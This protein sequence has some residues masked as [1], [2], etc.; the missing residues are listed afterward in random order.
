MWHIH[1]TWILCLAV[2][3]ITILICTFRHTILRWIFGI[4]SEMNDQ[5]LLWIENG[6]K[7]DVLNKTL[8]SIT[9]M[10]GQSHGEQ[11]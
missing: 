11:A 10:N 5:S 2:I 7:K 6:I 9:R 8:S 4:K 3:A 1:I